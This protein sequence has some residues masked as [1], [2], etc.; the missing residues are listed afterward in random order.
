MNLT[1]SLPRRTPTL[2]N[3]HH[4]IRK[5]LRQ[6]RSIT[7]LIRRRRD[8]HKR[9]STALA[10]I[11]GTGDHVFCASGAFDGDELHERGDGVDCGLQ[12]GEGVEGECGEWRGA[13]DEWD[14]G[15]G[16]LFGGWFGAEVGEYFEEVG[17]GGCFLGGVSWGGVMRGGYEGD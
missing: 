10:D 4:L 3:R 9:L 14:G 2:H 12:V 15:R 1:P 16:G 5:P 6:P 8:P 7:P 17:L 13:G 11:E